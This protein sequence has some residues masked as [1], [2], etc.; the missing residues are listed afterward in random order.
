MGSGRGAKANTARSTDSRALALCTR[1]SAPPD[2]PGLI[3]LLCAHRRWRNRVAAQ[4]KAHE[5]PSVSAFWRHPKLVA[6]GRC[7][8]GRHHRE[9]SVDAPRCVGKAGG[10]A[11]LF[12][13]ADAAS[14][15]HLPPCAKIRRCEEH[16]C[17][18]RVAGVPRGRLWFVLG[19]HSRGYEFPA[20]PTERDAGGGAS[21]S[22]RSQAP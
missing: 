10:N 11:G 21:A 4:Q 3:V 15:C 12:F 9:P 5:R 14:S 8:H 17:V 18:V 6:A 16:R 1:P 13:C 20:R 22:W 2:L 7:M 19:E